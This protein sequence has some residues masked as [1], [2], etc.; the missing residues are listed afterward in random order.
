MP[1]PPAQDA[2]VLGFGNG[3]RITSG[4]VRIDHPAAAG[5]RDRI[6]ICLAGLGRITRAHSREKEV[7]RRSGGVEGSIQIEPVPS[8]TNVG[9]IDSPGLIGGFQMRPSSI[10][11][12]GCVALNPAPDGGVIHS[13][14]PLFEKLLDLAIGKR[15]SQVST[16]GTEND[17]GSKMSPFEDRTFGHDCR[18]VGRAKQFLQHIHALAVAKQHLGSLDKVTRIVR[19]GV[20]MATVGDFRGHPKVADGASE[21][22]QDMFGKE[23]NPSRLVYGRRK[24]P[25]GTPVSWSSFS[26]LQVKNGGQVFQLI[27]EISKEASWQRQESRR[28]P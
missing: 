6:A 15:V 26:R 18:M 1:T 5:G 14:V 19:L 27:V 10:L 13:Q 22:L 11:K 8:N 17:L 7:D 24:P 28:H 4:F 3:S 12:F 21:L 20:S 2:S 25:L 9:F 23:R 16:D